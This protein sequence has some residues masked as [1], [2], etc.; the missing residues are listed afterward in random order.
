MSS[1]APALV[2]LKTQL[3]ARYPAMALAALGIMAD[4]AHIA[5]GTSDHIEGNALD[6]PVEM[7]MAHMKQLALEILKDGRV[8]YVI[9]D[10]V[11]YH[12][13]RAPTPYTGTS[14][15]TDHIHVSIYPA[16]RADAHEWDVEFST[17]NKKRVTS[18]YLGLHAGTSVFS[19]TLQ[20]MR[21]GNVVIVL[22]TNSTG[23]RTKVRHDSVV[24]WCV[25]SRLGPY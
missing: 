7:T 23:A 16:K 13:G 8:H 9:F 1:P 5:A 25:S 15:H 2:K 19:K 18:A 3:H 24:G 12:E 10:R 20:V 14:P 17:L 4:K 6:I 21:K 11:F 22:G